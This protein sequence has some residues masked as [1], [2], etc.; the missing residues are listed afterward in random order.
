MWRENADGLFIGCVGDGN[1]NENSQ[2]VEFEGERESERGRERDRGDE[3]EGKCE[4]SHL[5][6]NRI[7]FQ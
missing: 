7:N 4:L 3:R 1:E 2:R 6:Q 5:C